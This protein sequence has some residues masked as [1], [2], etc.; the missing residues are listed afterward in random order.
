MDWTLQNIALKEIFD[1]VT[2]CEMLAL[3]TV[4]SARGGAAL[5]SSWAPCSRWARGF[6]CCS[7]R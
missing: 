1:V 7:T 6:A 3:L 5:P 4:Y 2:L